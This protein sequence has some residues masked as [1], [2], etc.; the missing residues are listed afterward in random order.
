MCAHN[1]ENQ[2]YPWLRQKQRG[3][4]VKGNDSATLLCSDEAPPEVLFP[5]LESSAQERHGPIGA[6]PKQGHK[7]DQRDGRPLLCGKVEKVG[8]FSLEK[9]RLCKDLIAAF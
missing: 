8:L 6:G 7:K 1:P 5:S 9:R 2:P 3:Q 4:N